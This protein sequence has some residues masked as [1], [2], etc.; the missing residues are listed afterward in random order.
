MSHSPVM[1][2]HSPVMFAED[3]MILISQKPDLCHQFEE[4]THPTVKLKET[5]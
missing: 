2:S 3:L 1:L 4:H 5:I